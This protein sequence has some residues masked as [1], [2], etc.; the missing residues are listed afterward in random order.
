MIFSV[1]RSRFRLTLGLALGGLGRAALT[2][3]ASCA[4][5]TQQDPPSQLLGGTSSESPLAPQL[6]GSGGAPS[7]SP[8]VPSI[9]ASG[10]P[11][12]PQG[13]GG[14]SAPVTAP[15]S[16]AAG[17]GGASAADAGPVP[18]RG[19]PLLSE[20]FEA[21]QGEASGW[22]ASEGSLWELGPD[23]D[24]ARNSVYV[25]TETNGS[26]ANL[27]TAGEPDWQDLS[28]EADMVIL[29]F[30]GSSSSYLAGICV[31]VQDASRFYMIGVRSNDGKVGLRRFDGGGSNL[32][33]S[34]FEAGTTG[35]KYRLRVDVIGSTISAY[36]D[37]ALM[38]S[39]SDS[40]YARGGI[41]LC[42]VR[43]S[44]AFDRVQVSAL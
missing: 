25:Q 2:L 36:L 33:E 11:S 30:N 8:A 17:R 13:F 43:A 39:E 22:F 38:F 26:R 20:D 35:V 6:V 27:A 16:G 19:T 12:L 4:N 18:P 44:A 1:R 3:A 5:V 24:D 31:R 23:P 41:G 40:A 37:G 15:E 14:S 42:T 29:D 7:L 34:E 9:N 28:V 32:V 10:R 21:F